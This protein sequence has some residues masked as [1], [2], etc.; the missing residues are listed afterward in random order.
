M[1]SS[2]ASV[3]SSAINFS[4]LAISLF[5]NGNSPSATPSTYP[6]ASATATRTT[7]FH[8]RMLTSVFRMM[9]K[10]ST[11]L[12]DAEHFFD[13]NELLARFS[14]RGTAL[15]FRRVDAAPIIVTD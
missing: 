12:Q 15:D 6:A 2:S 13:A 14:D 5:V 4:A 8:A 11:R 3:N 9:R 1:E 10:V 7:I